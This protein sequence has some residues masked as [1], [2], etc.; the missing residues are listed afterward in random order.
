VAP[1][2]LWAELVHA[3]GDE[4]QIRLPG[5]AAHGSALA[6]VV[7]VVEGDGPGDLLVAEF[8]RSVSTPPLLVLDPARRPPTPADLERRRTLARALLANPTTSAG[9]EAT[10]VL[11]SGRVDPRLLSLLAALAGHFGLGVESL[12]SAPG[13]SLRHTPAREAVVDSVAGR[14]LTPGLPVTDTLVAYLD[15]QQPPFAPDRVEAAG[16]G[17]HVAFHYVS[18]PDA[19]VTG[20]TP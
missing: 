8:G 10:R 2:R 7:T 17:V 4:D 14:P 18:A 12:P 20:S 5:T 11:E 3:G 1:V 9:V 15:V 19:L 13:E 6:P 16:D